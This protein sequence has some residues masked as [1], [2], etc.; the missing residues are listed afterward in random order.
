MLIRLAMN[1][2]DTLKVMAWISDAQYTFKYVVDS[3]LARRGIANSKKKLSFIVART[4]PASREAG[5]R[6]AR[7][8]N[9]GY[10]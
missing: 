7:D 1:P 8:I 6:T 3:L 4:K 2:A 5:K 9:S 10:K